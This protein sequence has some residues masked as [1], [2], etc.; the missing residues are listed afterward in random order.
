MSDE[1][2]LDELL[3]RCTDGHRPEREIPVSSILPVLRDLIA[4][5]ERAEAV[6]EKVRAIAKTCRKRAEGKR[7]EGDERH[8]FLMSNDEREQAR[9]VAQVYEW[10]G[11]QLTGAVT[12]EDRQ[13]TD[14]EI[15][16][17]LTLQAEAQKANETEAGDE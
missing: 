12:F 2:T 14:A 9:R 6:V 17:G 4:K 5:A 3:D 15:Q 13:P 8:F 7:Q 11:L 10:I 16:Y 1:M